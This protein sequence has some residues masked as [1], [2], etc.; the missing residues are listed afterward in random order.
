[1]NPLEMRELGRTGLKVTRFGFG[2]APLGERFVPVDNRTA[3]EI[4]AHAG[5]SGIKFFDT[6]PQYGQ[7]KSEARLGRYLQT[8]PRD[9]YVLSTKVGHLYDRPG[10]PA[11]F[12]AALKGNG[13]HFAAHSDYSYDGVMRAYEHSLLRL[14]LNRVDLLVIHDLE[15]GHHGSAEKVEAHFRELTTGGG[16]RALEALKRAGEIKGIGCGIN[17][18]GTIPEILDRGDVDYFLVAMPYTLLDQGALDS[19][20]PRCAERGVAVV[21]GAV[22]A[23]GILATGATPDS[24]YAYGPAPEPVKGKVRQIEAVCRRHGVPLP[25]AAL[26]FPL[27]HPL[28]AAI[29]PGAHKVEALEKNLALM[30]HVIPSDLWAELVAEGLLRRD[31]PVP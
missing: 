17:D 21:I 31:A 1:M 28:V 13:L 11:G 4:L 3:D 24:R 19:E 9:S 23:S 29:I 14:G 26:Q 18:L 15:I 22:F 6:A 27:A 12:A 25:A 7:G 5:A 10:D 30:R 8:R 20:F 16:W 2:G